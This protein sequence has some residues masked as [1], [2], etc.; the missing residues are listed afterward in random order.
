M[1][2]C[3]RYLRMKQA[4]IEALT[5]EQLKLNQSKTCKVHKCILDRG[6]VY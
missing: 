3:V 6:I 5:M 2:N 1:E 4:V